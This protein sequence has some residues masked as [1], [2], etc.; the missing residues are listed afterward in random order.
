MAT[1][2]ELVDRDEMIPETAPDGEPLYEEIDGRRVEL[3]PMSTI[4]AVLASELVIALGAFARQ[5]SLGRAVVETLFR[6]PLP[7]S[8]NRRPDVAFVS[9]GRWPLDRP[10]PEEGNAWDVVPDLAVE[11]ISPTDS[12][13]ELW[14]KIGEYFRAGVRLVWVVMPR[15]RLVYVF[16]SPALVR[17]L[18]RAD[19]LDGGA[20]LSGF[21]LP[22]ASLFPEPPAPPTAPAAPPA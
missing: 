11:V 8:R 22:L 20:V 3:P 12:V 9:V 4:A 6:L 18:T 15:P 16:E 1:V 10:I 21:T 17:G 19:T 7:V 13:E 2:I 5:R 14:D